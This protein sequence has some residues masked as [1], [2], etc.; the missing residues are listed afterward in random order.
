[1]DGHGNPNADVESIK[2]GREAQPPWFGMEREHCH[3]HGEGDGGMRRRPAPKNPSTQK[4]KAE[5]MA[6]VRADGVRRM[7]AAGNRL[8]GG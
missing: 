5:D 7:N 4:T 3:G 8:V 2:D 1:M 6:Y